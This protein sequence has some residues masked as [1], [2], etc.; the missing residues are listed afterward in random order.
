MNSTG[1]AL[2]AVSPRVAGL[3]G[4]FVAADGGVDS[5]SVNPAGIAG[6]GTRTVSLS[7][8]NIADGVTGVQLNAAFPVP[9]AGPFG[10]RLGYVLLPGTDGVG[11]SEFLFSAAYGR[12]FFRFLD[13]GVSAGLFN[14]AIDGR[15]A[16]AF[17]ADLGVRA[18]FL[19]PG[20]VAK[21]RVSGGVSL[22]NLGTGM[23]FVSD[24]VG[25][26]N[27]LVLGGSYGTGRLFVAADARFL[28][29]Y[30][31]AA[32]Y[33]G[34]V[35]YALSG[36]ARLRGG[37]ETDRSQTRFYFGLSFGVSVASVRTTLDYA[38]NPVSASGRS[39]HDAGLT[40][41]F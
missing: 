7:Y 13:A 31:G 18:S 39:G 40:T 30:G 11:Y 1:L 15:A 32:V 36:A 25:L 10:V 14:A 17:T 20:L 4:A 38:F 5:L 27:W 8:E 28:L 26:N 19:V 6:I 29:N 33:A 41:S 2:D 37:V 24:R 9:R 3:A 35:E 16:T 21:H 34:G 23:K 22:R 12:R